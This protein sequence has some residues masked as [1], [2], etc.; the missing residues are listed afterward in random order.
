MS[1]I[2]VEVSITDV[3]PA[4][5]GGS[6]EMF[7]HL[8]AS[9]DEEGDGYITVG[10]LRQVHSYQHSGCTI[11]RYVK[12]CVTYLLCFLDIGFLWI[13]SELSPRRKAEVLL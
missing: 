8:F 7:V 11:R 4:D 12:L 10:H 2:V 1:F 5:D 3:E 9:L 6:L 13:G